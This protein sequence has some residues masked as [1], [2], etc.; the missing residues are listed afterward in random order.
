MVNLT[1]RADRKIPP[2]RE[3]RDGKAAYHID[4]RDG[5]QD[6]ET[7]GRAERNEEKLDERDYED[8]DGENVI[9]DGAASRLGGLERLQEQRHEASQHQNI[10]HGQPEHPARAQGEFCD[11]RARSQTREKG[12]KI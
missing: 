11:L 1:F 4:K 3:D 12:K 6:E 9:D 2:R 8:D 7:R 5:G 10:A